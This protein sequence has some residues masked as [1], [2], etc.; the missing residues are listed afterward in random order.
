MSLRAAGSPPVD[1]KGVLKAVLAS[2]GDARLLVLSQH[3]PALPWRGCCSEAVA[4]G[5]VPA[6]SALCSPTSRTGLEVLP[7][8][9][10]FFG[11]THG[12]DSWNLSL[13]QRCNQRLVEG[14][15]EKPGSG[16]WLCYC[17][18][19]PRG[20]VPHRSQC[21]CPRGLGSDPPSC[22]PCSSAPGRTASGHDCSLR[23][24][25]VAPRE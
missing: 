17:S 15:V 2:P 25:V 14:H 12:A 21:L 10:S 1:L 5:P 11:S 6:Y 24:S 3:R 16:G 23:P 9:E 4:F 19:C 8:G 18:R 13:V 20:S 22:S 7:H